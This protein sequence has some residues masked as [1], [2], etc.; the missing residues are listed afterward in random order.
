VNPPDVSPVSDSVRVPRQARSRRTLERL[1][2]AAL[3]LVA[4]DGPDSVTVA[5]V[6]ARAR[7]SVGSFYAR[8]QG[9]DE[10]FLHL[11]EGLRRQ[12]LDRWDA[13]DVGSAS[14][15]V[16]ATVHFLV[17]DEVQ[18]GGRRRALLAQG[19]PGADGG[20]FSRVVAVDLHRA[21][22]GSSGDGPSRE[23]VSLAIRMVR[24]SLA[25][26]VPGSPGMAADGGEPVAPATLRPL[27]EEVVRVVLAGGKGAAAEAVEP[28]DEGAVEAMVEAVEPVEPV[29]PPVAGEPVDEAVEDEAVDQGVEPVEE[30]TPA[31]AQPERSEPS[32]LHEAPLEDESPPV[33][34]FDV[35]G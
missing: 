25:A 11:A 3:E 15:P 24:A 28:V 5:Q 35:W 20:E 12:A 13:L 27:L 19:D 22:S 8:F 31:P 6:V 1:E 23:A 7:S 14:D 16:A 2:K 4:R 32:D 34:P 21:L 30:G 33:D 17:E 10:L 29:E 9:K 26:L 18:G